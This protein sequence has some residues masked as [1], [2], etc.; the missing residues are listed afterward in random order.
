MYLLYAPPEKFG[1]IPPH[2]PMICDEVKFYNNY[3]YTNKYYYKKIHCKAGLLD[4]ST[5]EMINRR[6]KRDFNRVLFIVKGAIGDSLWNMPAIRLFKEKFPNCY[7]YVITDKNSIDI[8]RNCQYINGFAEDIFS[9]TQQ[10]ILRSEEV[11]E[12][13]GVATIYK[14]QMKL[15]PC[16]AIVKELGLDI[17]KEK[18]K[19]R[20][21][22]FLTVDE[23]QA[24][25][26]FLKKEG[27]NIEK[28]KIV[29]FGVD[30]STSNR[31]YPFD[32]VKAVSKALI[33]DGYKVIW[34]GKTEEY[35][36][37]HLKEEDKIKGVINQVGKTNL[38]N[39]MMLISLSNLHINPNSGLMVI[40]TAL[41]VP[42]IGLFGAFEPKSRA[43]YY[44]RFKAL[45]EPLRCS[46]CNEHWTECRHGHPAPC[47]RKISPR[48]LYTACKEM[49]KKE[50][51]S[52]LEKMPLK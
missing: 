51:R 31:H 33:N 15:D 42:T 43:K 9:N 52:S 22:L 17:P 35:K 1:L 26:D 20:P 18:E 8:W 34:I 11:Y 40:S 44:E 30:A 13:T 32:Y 39:V 24:T 4:V 27:V 37:E 14:D 36:D 28:H 7:I 25:V 19:M 29:T 49:L 38:R 41:N 3:A 21:K 2:I 6:K 50:P 46:P 12:F 47:M 5:K 16:E 48:L 23:G 45:Y 10:L